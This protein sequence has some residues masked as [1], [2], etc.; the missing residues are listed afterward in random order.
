MVRA[1]ELDADRRAPSSSTDTQ[2]NP[3]HRHNRFS[4][5]R[6]PRRPVLVRSVIVYVVMGYI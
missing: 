1:L 6:N 4:S 2:R 3:Y 5:N